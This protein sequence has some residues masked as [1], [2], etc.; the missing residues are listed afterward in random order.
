M[1]LWLH[2]WSVWLHIFLTVMR[3]RH[4]VGGDLWRAV[5]CARCARWL[6]WGQHRGH[7]LYLLKG[8]STTS[9][10]LDAL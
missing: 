4:G 5:Q 10:D 6:V 2:S 9:E 8:L 3:K 7:Q 1:K